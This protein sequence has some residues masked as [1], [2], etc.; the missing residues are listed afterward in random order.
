MEQQN[1][2]QGPAI[3]AAVAVKLPPFWTEDPSTWFAQAEA[4]FHLRGVSSDE[5][6]LYYV[7]AAL[8][9]TTARRLLD[10]IRTPP[11]QNKY[12]SIKNRLVTI[13]GILH[14]L[15]ADLMTTWLNDL[16]A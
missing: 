15:V 7:V 1:Q 12:Q 16:M 2:A 3:Q 4:Q 11:Q 8:D 10:I 9:Q 13:A 6:K 5:T 14:H